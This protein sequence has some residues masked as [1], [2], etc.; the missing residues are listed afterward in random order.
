MKIKFQRTLV[1]VSQKV[2]YTNPNVKHVDGKYY[3]WFW[4]EFSKAKNK[5][6]KANKNANKSR[7]INR[8]P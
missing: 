2:L 3:I 7:K 6:R 4:A 8:K 1:E 5:R